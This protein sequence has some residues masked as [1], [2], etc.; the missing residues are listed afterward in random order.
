MNPKTYRACLLRDAE[1]PIIPG[2]GVRPLEEIS[3]AFPQGWAQIFR[4]HY[5]C[6]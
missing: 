4:F 1:E 6:S 5:R 3:A 2:H